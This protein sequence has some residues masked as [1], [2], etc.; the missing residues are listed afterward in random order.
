MG[1]LTVLIGAGVALLIL[2]VLATLVL[3]FLGTGIPLL[4]LGIRRRLG[5]RSRASKVAMIILGIVCGLSF[6]ILCLILVPPF[7]WGGY[8]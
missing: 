7:F 4:V 6:L 2:L 3:A 5:H 1:G 8:S